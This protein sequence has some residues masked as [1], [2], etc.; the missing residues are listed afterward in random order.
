MA[1]MPGVVQTFAEINPVTLVLNAARDLTIGQGSAL[2]PALE[3]IAWLVVR[4]RR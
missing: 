3:A 1:S 4:D 2:H